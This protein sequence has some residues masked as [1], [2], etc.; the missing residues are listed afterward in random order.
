MTTTED[1]NSNKINQFGVL[2][3]D[4]DS[5]F[6]DST[7]VST[8]QRRHTAYQQNVIADVHQLEVSV[9]QLEDSWIAIDREQVDNNW[10]IDTED[11]MKVTVKALEALCAKLIFSLHKYDTVKLQYLKRLLVDVLSQFPNKEYDHGHA[12]LLEDCKSF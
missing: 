7:T 12:Y 2:V 3:S 8:I 5:I 9:Q 11:T 6:E 4:S 1:L 10:D